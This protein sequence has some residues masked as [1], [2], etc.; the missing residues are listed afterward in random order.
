MQSLLKLFHPF[1]P[2]ITE[3]IYLE[4]PI[5]EE[6]IM[7]SSWPKAGQIKGLKNEFY[8]IIDVIKAIRNTRSQFNVP[9]N[10]RTKLYVMS[11]F[12]IVKQNLNEIAKL[13]FGTE[14]EMIKQE[15]SEKCAK[16]IT[17]FASI[18]IPMGQLVDNEQERDRLNKE[19]SSI[20]FEIERSSK[21]LS[22]AGFVAKAPTSLVENEKAKLEK[23]K[24]LLEK[25]ENQLK[26]L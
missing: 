16:V 1:I 22:N 3:K 13:G 9:D 2:F 15:P 11:N 24:L 4:L 23:N 20:K 14:C 10:K 8:E 5:H 17:N 18:F 6:T 26:L 25:L 19:I 12:T 7:L 21:M